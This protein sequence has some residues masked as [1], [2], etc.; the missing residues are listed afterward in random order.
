MT[1]DVTFLGMSELKEEEGM[2]ILAVAITVLVLSPEAVI[3][4]MPTM[5]EGL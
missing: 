5:E 2:S 4:P 3:E 1:R